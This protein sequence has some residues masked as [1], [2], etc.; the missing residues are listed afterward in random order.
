VGT[1]FVIRDADVRV[2]GSASTAGADTAEVLAAA[3]LSEDEVA[4]LAARGVFG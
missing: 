2:R 4:E 1:P 3:G